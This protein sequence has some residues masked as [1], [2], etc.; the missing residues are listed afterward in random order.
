[1]T[2]EYAVKTVKQ[3]SVDL[4]NEPGTLAVFAESLTKA[5]VLIEGI[6]VESGH[7]VSRVHFVVDKPT[8]ATAV[9][10]E[11]GENV[12]IKEILSVTLLERKM[13]QIAKIA[14]M[15]ADAQINIDVIYLTSAEQ[16]THPTIYISAS[17]ASVTDVAA[18]LA[19]LA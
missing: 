1:M 15:L 19:A 14:R 9:L 3:I 6:S 12:S 13:G 10:T 2:Q 8:E 7:G 11:L 17:N 5:S 16:G 4:S 18:R